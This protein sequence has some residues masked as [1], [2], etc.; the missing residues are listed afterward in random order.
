MPRVAQHGCINR[1]VTAQFQGSLGLTPRSREPVKNDLARIG[2]KESFK[3]IQNRFH[4][5]NAVDR[6][7]LVTS[8][9]AAPQDMLKY[10]LLRFQ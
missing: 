1:K 6:D 10:P 8:L 9:S 7:D 4:R 5:P 2:G 3:V